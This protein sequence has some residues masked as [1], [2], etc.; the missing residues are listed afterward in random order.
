MKSQLQRLEVLYGSMYVWVLLV[1]VSENTLESIVFLIQLDKTIRSSPVE[2][3]LEKGVL[4]IC[5]EFA[6]EH[7]CPIAI[8]IRVVLRLY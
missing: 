1:L 3:L 4:K 5:N 8:S 6:G 2:L 7:P